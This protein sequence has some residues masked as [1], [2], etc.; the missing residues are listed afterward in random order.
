MT[1]PLLETPVF[2][3]MLNDPKFGELAKRILD[4]PSSEH[5]WPNSPLVHGCFD[6]ALL[7]DFNHPV[8]C[9]ACST[10]LLVF[11]LHN[12]QPPRDDRHLALPAGSPSDASRLQPARVTRL[13]RPRNTKGPKVGY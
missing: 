4:H 6:S 5:E 3:T 10:H 11:T 9:P 2:A 7:V 1:H 13:R 8:D 12:P